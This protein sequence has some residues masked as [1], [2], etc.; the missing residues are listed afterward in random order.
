MF[1]GK[2]KISISEKNENVPSWFNIIIRGHSKYNILVLIA[3][4]LWAQ[5]KRDLILGYCTWL[6]SIQLENIRVFVGIKSGWESKGGSEFA[7]SL[8]PSFPSLLSLLIGHSLLS[9]FLI[10][11]HP[12]I[13]F[14]FFPLQPHTWHHLT[15]P[16]NLEP[17]RWWSNDHFAPIFTRL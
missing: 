10:G 13:S 7:G 6:Q 5:A 9:S 14:L 12:L 1:C 16:A 4:N 11:Q 3:R 17:S 8:L 2:K 15:A